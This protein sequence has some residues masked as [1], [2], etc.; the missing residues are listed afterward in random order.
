ME[1]D[2]PGPSLALMR[3]MWETVVQQLL[4]GM[5]QDFDFLLPGL[6][7]IILQSHVTYRIEEIERDRLR[8]N[9]SRMQ[10]LLKHCYVC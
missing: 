9:R 2:I 10:T 1:P 3:H 4:V 6:T 5:Q 7:A 8:N